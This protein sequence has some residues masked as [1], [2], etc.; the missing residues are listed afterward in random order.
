[1]KKSIFSLLVVI[2]LWSCGNNRIETDAFGNFEVTE[3]NLSAPLAGEI[4][5]LTPEEGSTIKQGQLVGLIDTTQLY[6]RKKQLMA[7]QQLILSRQPGIATQI[8]V[9]QEQKNNARREY[10]RFQKLAKEGA[11]TPKQVDDLQDRL[12]VLEKQI[13]NVRSQMGPVS[14]E[15]KMVSAQI[16]QIESQIADASIVAP[17][18]ATVIVK[19]AEA[20][21]M[22][23]PG[24]PML[25][26]AKMDTL[27]L[28]AFVSGTQLNKIKLG[29]Q[30]TVLTDESK[31][32]MVS[33]QGIVRWISSQAEFTPKIIQTKEERVDLVYA[34]KI[35]VPN[36]EGKLKIGM[37]AE[38]ALD[39]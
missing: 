22:V 1:M 30:V 27:M 29:Q 3:I 38:V 34:V 24:M 5:Y 16:E 7:Q 20:S 25:R 31:E 19:L 23:Q 39:Y 21:E 10:E 14:H 36:P 37:P 11:A 15:Y 35:A 2:V 13:Q 17:I 28:R 33:H 9:L 32:K 8:E 18:S 12:V 6:L 4:M 26:I